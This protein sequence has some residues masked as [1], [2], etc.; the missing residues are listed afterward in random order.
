M[1]L[2]FYSQLNAK[3]NMAS[4][5]ERKKMNIGIVSNEMFALGCRL[6]LFNV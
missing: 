3:N 2:Y 5:C 6:V 1:Y 4:N